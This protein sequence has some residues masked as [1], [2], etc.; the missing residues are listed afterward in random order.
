MEVATTTCNKCGCHQSNVVETRWVKVGGLDIKMRKRV[1]RYCGNVFRTKEI[2]D[3][4]IK[5]P[6]IT[7]KKDI[8]EL[9]PPQPTVPFPE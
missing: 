4:E 9:I 8:A 3:T 6:A 5:F 1:C 2:I 7:R